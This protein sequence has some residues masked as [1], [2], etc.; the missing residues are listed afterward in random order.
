MEH[1][2]VTL[3][4]GHY[5]S[6][7]TNIAVNY[8]LLLSARGVLDARAL[9]FEGGSVCGLAM[10]NTLAGSSLTLTRYDYNVVC[11]NSSTI[12]LTLPT[13]QLYD[14]GHVIRIRQ[15][16]TATV[17]VQ[18]SSCYTYNGTSTRYS[19]PLIQFS[20]GENI[21][22][23][24]A[25]TSAGQGYAIELVWVRDITKTIGSTTYYGSWVMYR[26]SNI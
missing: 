10:R 9:A 14:D 25:L 20:S 24:N 3:F 7:T 18:A 26:L 21:T 17:K 4:A 19:A 5:G 12:T 11:V 23:G 8:A 2:R 22:P 16:N 1:K 6:G 15:M 13:M